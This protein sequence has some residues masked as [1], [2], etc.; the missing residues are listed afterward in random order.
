MDKRGKER[1]NTNYG[2]SLTE[3]L[4]VI[5]VMLFLICILAYPVMNYVNRV[6]VSADIQTAENIRMAIAAAL[7]DPK[8]EQDPVSREYIEEIM[9]MNGTREKAVAISSLPDNVFTNTVAES[10]G[11]GRAKLL[12]QDE[13]LRS[14]PAEEKG[15]ALKMEIRFW[16]SKDRQI[17][18]VICGSNSGTNDEEGRPVPIMV[19]R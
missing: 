16:I 19:Y 2:F 4:V 5:L 14:A 3:L 11:I 7:M 9:E 12:L 10:M 8:V 17:G 18:V 13:Q 15:E 1:K 6:Q